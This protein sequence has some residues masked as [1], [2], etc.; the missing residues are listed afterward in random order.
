MKKALIVYYS[1]GEV[2]C[3]AERIGKKLLEKQITSQTFLIE[4]KKNYSLKDQFKKEKELELKNKNPPLNE[5]NYLFIGSPVVSFS[6]AP[7]V[8][9]FL[10][11]LDSSQLKNKKIFLFATGIGLP[12]N[13]IKKMSSILSMKGVGVEKERVFSSIFHFDEKKLKEVDEF[14]KEII[15]KWIRWKII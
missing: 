3:V 15:K 2:G 12:G 14:I 7:I 10:K 13:T 8:N 5:I 1:F 11:N 9:V 4:D 6:S